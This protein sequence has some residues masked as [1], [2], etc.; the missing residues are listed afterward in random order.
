MKREVQWVAKIRGKNIMR[1]GHIY[2][3]ELEA[4][5]TGTGGDDASGR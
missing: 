5:S 4:V 2:Q 1:K 3:T